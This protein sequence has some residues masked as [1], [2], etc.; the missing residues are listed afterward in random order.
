MAS[1]TRLFDS[2]VMTL[3]EF[4]LMRLAGLEWRQRARD[5][6]RAKRAAR[7]RARKYGDLFAGGGAQRELWEA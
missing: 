7:R 6:R 4:V 1:Q 2:P 3:R 5:S